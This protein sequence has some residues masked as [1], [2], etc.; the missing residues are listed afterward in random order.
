MSDVKDFERK[1]ELKA[2]EVK[3]E[4]LADILNKEGGPYHPGFEWRAWGAQDLMLVRKPGVRVPELQ[5]KT[6]IKNALGHVY[7]DAIDKE[8]GEHFKGVTSSTNIGQVLQ[9][10]VSDHSVIDKKGAV[11]GVYGKYLDALFKSK[12]RAHK[13]EMAAVRAA[14]KAV[15]R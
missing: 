11:E 5:Y 4:R 9:V 15:T 13:E 10:H 7:L 3:M 1:Q 12:E 8:A 2:M 6:N 14:K